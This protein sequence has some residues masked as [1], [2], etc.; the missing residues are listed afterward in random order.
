MAQHIVL[1]GIDYRRAP[2]EVRE[3]L[4]FAPDQALQALPRLVE[5]D[6]VREALLLATCNRTEFYLAYDGPS[7]VASLLEYLRGLRRSARALHQDCLRF[8]ESGDDA[9]RHLFRVA[10]GIDSQILGDTHIVRQVKQ[11]QRLAVEAATLGPLLDRAVT[12]SLRAAKRARRE[13]G[14]GRGAASVGAA[15]LRS[16]R[17]VFADPARV[18]VLV[19]GAGQAG[20]DIAYH[21]AKVPFASLTFACRNPD[22]AAGMAREFHGCAAEWKDVPGQL[23]AVEVVIAATAARLPFL[24][25]NIVGARSEEHLEP[26]LIVDAG[27]PRNADPTVAELPRVH[28]LNLDALDQEQEQSLEARRREIPRVEAILA[29]ELERWKRWWQRRAPGMRAE[30]GSPPPG[31]IGIGDSPP[32]VASQQPAEDWNRHHLR[33][34][35][36]REGT[37]V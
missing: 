10:A 18:R 20:R 34:R 15:V 5:I 21:L 25:R 24:D 12:E 36:D 13:T 19:L 33:R 28:L 26:L 1:A 27:I 35:W 6:G 31:P 2:V 14:I 11:A 3:E 7:P 8:V 29:E 37:H 30:L 32:A 16:V 17:R 9:V 23:P 22:Q 4:S